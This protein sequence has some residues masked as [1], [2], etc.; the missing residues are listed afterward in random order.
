MNSTPF[1]LGIVGDSGSGK[2]TVADAVAE[3]LGRDRSV[4]LRLD[5]YHR[6]SR[7]E[8]AG[9]G[10]TALNPLVHNFALMQEHLLMLREG[11]TVRNRSY[12]HSDGS[13]GPTTQLEPR[14]VVLVRGLLGYPNEAIRDLYHLTVF[15]HPEPD[16]LFRWK[17]RRDVLFRGY[18]EAEVLKSIA[19]HLL[20]SKEFVTPQADR[21]DVVVRYELPDWEAPDSEVITTITLRRG[22]AETARSHQLVNGFS[23]VRQQASGEDVVLRLETSI[24]AEAVESWGR[25]LFPETYKPGIAGRYMDETGEPRSR[26]TLALVEI[27]IARLAILMREKE[28]ANEAA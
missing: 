9:L 17:L 18:R 3:L 24:S 22:P 23:G 20:D 6:Y 26:P 27:L 4:D 16:L 5:D 10:L 13:F 19:S 14:D 11:R 15:L 12:N 8:R 28:P 25:E 7:E 1:L 2:N 21:A